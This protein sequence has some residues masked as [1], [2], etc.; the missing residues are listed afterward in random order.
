MIRVLLRDLRGRL[1]A[2]A[3]VALLFY[4]LEPAYHRHEEE[5]PDLL[6]AVELGPLGVSAT[7]AFLSAVAMVVLLAGF[8]S[9]D[10][11][12]GYTRLYF[13]NPTSPLAYY[14][15]RWLLAL[16]LTM[17]LATLFLFGGQLL[18]WGEIRG[19]G[20]GLL[21]ALLFAVVYGGMTA[22]FSAALP[23]GDAWV[24]A[25][26][27]LLHFFWS[28]I[29]PLANLSGPGLVAALN[30]LVLPRLPL[31]QVRDG[32]LTGRMAWGGALFSALYGLVWAAGGA[33]LVRLREW[34]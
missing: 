15:L 9:E 19:G 1:A 31:E 33:L 16:A 24:V 28:F 23:R 7:L 10:R 17:A 27:L 8:V 22:F 26:V 20:S 2:L 3:A 5:T 21:L 6:N 4:L 12:E 25:F 14:A 11:R 18:A 30:L 13:A 29:A 34:P 32:I